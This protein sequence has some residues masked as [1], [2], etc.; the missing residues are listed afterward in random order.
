MKKVL[1]FG[2]SGSVGKNAL[3][4]IKKAPQEFKVAGLCTNQDI[5]TLEGQINEFK[6]KYVCVKDEA[7]AKKLEKKLK[8]KLKLFKGETGLKEF[9][10]LT[11]DISVMAISGI[12]C[13]AP[14]VTNIKHVKR[15]ALANKE[16]VVVAGKLVFLEARRRNTEIL[17]VDS[18]INALFQLLKGNDKQLKK[19]YLTASGGPFFD[20]DKKDLKKVGPKEVLSHPTWQMGRRI[21]VDS[22]T[23][24]NKGFEVIETERFFNIGFEKIKVVIHRESAIHALVE[25]QDHTMFAC[26]YPPDMKMPISFSLYYP[27]RAKAGGGIDFSKGFSLSFAPVD[28]KKYP[29]LG[30]VLDV[31]KREDNGL[32]VLNAC[33]EVTI[34]YFLE[35]KIK[36]SAIQKVMEY[37][38]QHYP[39]KKIKS[40]EDVLYWDKWTRN[41]TGEYLDKLC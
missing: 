5:K 25:Y 12:S 23:L 33:D 7:A 37:F 21:T 14:L 1:V 29:L 2:S 3:S 34:Q 41:K 15:V 10:S 31:A 36:F 26:L 4:V 18:E 20:Y 30:I 32:C 24:V 22:A 38:S 9:S 35:K 28:Y 40:I 13:L 27:R 11:A 8:G 17:P 16:S 19:V 39:S 6:P